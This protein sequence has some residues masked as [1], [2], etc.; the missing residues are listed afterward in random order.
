MKYSW[1][2]FMKIDLTGLFNGSTETINID[3][4]VD[5]TDFV[6]SELNDEVR[7]VGSA[8]S[9][10]DVVYLDLDISY[11][12]KGQCDRCAEDVIKNQSLII[13]RIIAESLQNEDDDDNYIVVDNRELDLD[14]FICEEILLNLPSKLL[15]KDD[16]KGLCAKC[17]ANLNVNKC[18][19]KK[20]VDSRMS[21][22]L[23][24]LEED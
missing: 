6:I 14:G 8:Y 24:L 18:D 7:A 19:C 3:Y 10:A 20:E 9:K 16:C 4:N 13:N 12:I 11:S 15:C 21:A 17:G 22:L 5:L 23:Q 2:D 1:G